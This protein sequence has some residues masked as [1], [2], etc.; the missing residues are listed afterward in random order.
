MLNDPIQT[1][2]KAADSPYTD[3]VVR[4]L[5]A[6]FPELEIRP[7]RLQDA[8]IDAYLDYK[9]T[10]RWRQ[11][12]RA[13]H[14]NNAML[15]VKRLTWHF[16]AVGDVWD[17]IPPEAKQVLQVLEGRVPRLGKQS[18]RVARSLDAQIQISR[19]RRGDHSRNSLSRIDLAPVEEFAWA[20]SFY[21]EREHPTVPFGHN[22]ECTGPNGTDPVAKSPALKLL[23]VCLQHI[24]PN[25]NARDCGSAIRHI[26]QKSKP[27]N[28]V[29]DP[30][31]MTFPAD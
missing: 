25:I 17:T 9:E 18:G 1:K 31:S 13:L 24:D 10:E 28:E 3:E 29:I 23:L 30:D 7:D 11:I 21:W 20:F 5:A 8:L 27:S 4:E 26:K 19:R 22:F 15:L 14:H 6:Q 2:V 12:K 16:H